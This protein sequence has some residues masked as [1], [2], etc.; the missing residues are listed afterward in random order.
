MY[1]DRAVVGRSGY[2][3]GE[4]E[5]AMRSRALVLGILGFGS[6]IASTLWWLF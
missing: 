3:E 1:V 4:K 6:L 5:G 2:V